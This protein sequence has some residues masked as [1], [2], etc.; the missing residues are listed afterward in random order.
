MSLKPDKS[1]SPA[2]SAGRPPS[3]YAEGSGNRTMLVGMEVLEIVA[4]MEAPATLTTI[5]RHAGMSLTRTSRYLMS[6]TARLPAAGRGDGKFD[7]GP[8]VLE[9]G[10]AAM[11][12]MDAVR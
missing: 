11:A 10:M 5:A 8:A 6:L 3:R 12:R 2:P 1:R 4:H 9:L 7:L